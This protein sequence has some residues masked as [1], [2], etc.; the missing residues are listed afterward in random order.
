MTRGSFIALAVSLQD[1]V[2]A[3]GVF[4]TRADARLCA[5]WHGVTDPDVAATRA[6]ALFPP[7]GEPVLTHNTTG[8]EVFTLPDEVMAV[9]E[10]GTPEATARDECV[11]A[12]VTVPTREVRAA[13]AVG[14]FDGAQARRWLADALAPG[15]GRPAECRLLPVRASALGAA[16]TPAATPEAPVPAVVL[17]DTSNGPICY[18]PFDSALD[19]ALFWH[20]VTRTLDLANV[21]RAHVCDLIPPGPAAIPTPT[22][23]EPPG[24]DRVRG[25]VVRLQD[26]VDADPRVVGMFADHSSARAW[27]PEYSSPETTSPQDLLPVHQP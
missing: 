12:L 20:D 8:G 24:D 17:L 16:R 10:N 6:V 3:H 15:R 26:R 19:A 18:G 11:I 22:S 5:D 7:D 9:L 13:F 27:R 4:G 21:H 25:W 1:G 14:P 2:V 23:E